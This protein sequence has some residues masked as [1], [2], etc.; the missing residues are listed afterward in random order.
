MKEYDAYD[1]IGLAGLV[2]NGEVSPQE[3]LEAAVE[4]IEQHNPALNAVVHTMFDQARAALAELPRGPFHGVPFLLK[5]LEVAVAGEPLSMGSRALDGFRPPADNEVARRLR[6]TGLNFLGKTNCP[7]FGLMGITEP[8]RWGP[9]RNPFN[10]NHTPGGSSGG[11]AA[12]VAAGMVPMASGGDGGGSLRIPASC[13]GLLGLK[14]SRGRVPVGPNHGEIWEGAV[15][16]HVLTRTVRD[17]AAMLD[18]LEGPDCGAPFDIARPVRPYSEEIQTS[19]EPQKIAFSTQSPLG[20][21]VDPICVEAVTRTARFL[22]DQGHIVE[23]AAPDHDGAYLAESYI[24]MY[25]GQID[26]TIRYLEHLL[27]RRIKPADVEVGTWAL[28]L[29]GRKLSAGEYAFRRATWNRSAR[30]LGN[31]MQNYDLWLTPTLAAPPMKIGEL[32]MSP[33]E[34]RLLG[35]INRLN[36]TG[37]LKKRIRE[38]SLKNLHKMP[39]T[40][41]ANMTGVPAVS[42]PLH[43]HG[44]LPIGVQFTARFGD[45]ARLLRLAAMFEQSELWMPINALPKAD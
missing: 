29:L 37:L 4:R 19:L 14:P 32:A 42:L 27:E 39:F 34:K 30:S 45:E 12:A 35:L 7:E 9:C 16:G 41:L 31:L 2:R 21:P 28:R 11:S 22:E 18:I 3:L 25:Q 23:E 36:L 44:D 33:G 5:D 20:G 13:C 6:A 40:Q 43:H 15:V 1:G 38:E 24:I 17:C 8:E 26:A 10:P